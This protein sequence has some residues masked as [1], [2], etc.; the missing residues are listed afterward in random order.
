MLI[1]ACTR[2]A[3]LFL[4]AEQCVSQTIA[5]TSRSYH[6]WCNSVLGS[7]LSNQPLTIKMTD[8][9]SILAPLRADVRTQGDIVRR[10][11]SEK[12]NDVEIQC[13]VAELK[14]RKK[15]LEEKV[16]MTKLTKQD[17]KIDRSKLEDLLKQ[18]FVYDQSFSIYG[19]VQGLYD[20]GPTGCAIKAN[21]L[22]AWRQFFVL[23]EQ[24][25]EVDCS[26]LTPECVLKASGH[27][28]RFTDYMVRDAVTGECFR[29]DHLIEAALKAI[30]FSKCTSEAEKSEID[31]CLSQLEGFSADELKELI[32]R[33]SIKSPITKN[34]LTPPQKFNLMFPTSI[35]PTGQ[36][37]GFLRPE[38]AQG[39]FVNFQRLLHFNQGRLPFGAAQIG[40]AFRNEIS[41]RSGVIRV[42]EFTMAEIEYFVD[43]K[44]KSHPKFAQYADLKLPLFSACD[45]MD[46]KSTQEVPLKDA[47]ARGIIANETLGYF[48]ARIF[49]FLYMVGVKPDRCR[50]RQH[51]KNEMAHYARDCWDAECLTTY[52]WIECVGCAD[53]SCFDLTQHQ[54]ATGARLT[55]EKLLPE[56][57]TVHEVKCVPNKA[58]IGQT[59]R[60]EAAQILNTFAALSPEASLKIK[61][62]LASSGKYA[63]LV[64]GSQFEVTSDMVTVKEKDVRVH[65]E[66]IVPSVIEPSFGIGRIMYAI[67][68]QNFHT[69]EDDEQRTYLSL[70]PIIAPYKCSV[71]PLS[72]HPDFVPF[73][74]HLS[75]ELTRV[76]ISHRVD[77]SGGSI[78]RRYARTDQIAIPYGITIDF[79][80]VNQKP[81]SASLRE[82]ETM[83]QIRVPIEDLPDLVSDLANG[84]VS[85]H[86]ALANYPLFEHQEASK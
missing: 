54:N 49:L 42:R 26:M 72:S 71:L 23:E 18:R 13:A 4:R 5:A 76:G 1:G 51:M 83:K 16:E 14:A 39:I 35:G 34:D 33:Y 63:L 57:V 17:H 52:G 15:M 46:G 48:M 65:V 2:V 79:D 9:E 64:N 62:E 86:D 50:F 11:K 21:L 31:K 80:T 27:L 30:R 7:Y 59:Y 38:T 10:L 3:S 68:E 61:E 60:G 47:V 28:E 70:P 73:V 40:S 43:P 32:A 25:L 82:R 24:L 41:P 22:A 85:W 19:G 53:R 69:R 8:V 44:D 67:L 58:K 36:Y 20:Y 56:P 78:G 12:A 37:H 55:A 45:Q 77:E 84:I 81:P 75:K 6:R 74:R 66:E 29:A